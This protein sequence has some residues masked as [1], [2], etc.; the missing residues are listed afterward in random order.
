MEKFLF[1][2]D[3]HFG[4]ER[5]NGHKGPLHDLRAW[6]A[7]VAFAQDFKPD[8]WIMGG[9]MLDC[10]VI[11]H[12]NK[13]KPGR[14][15]GLRLISDAAECAKLVVEPAA[16]I[17]G[18]G[19]LVYMVGNHEDWLQDLV[20]ELPAL[21]GMLDIETLLGLDGWQIVRQGKEF[22]KGKLLFVHGDKVKGGEHVAKA[23]VIDYENSIRFGHHHT[24]QTYTKTTPTGNQLAKT[25]IAVPCLCGKDPKY[26][27]S[28]PNRWV[29]GFLYGYILPG[30]LFHDYV[31]TIINGRT[32]IGG[33]VYRG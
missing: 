27:E 32:V 20:E 11:S 7:V 2:T 30:G 14:T 18:K 4:Y 15:E 26:G 8:L 16:K 12:H 31:A 25:G 23:A 22:R 24:Y 17:V 33:K 5:R 21:S 28:R 6:G 9:D 3:L 10:G 1:T 13:A 29:Q 19:Q